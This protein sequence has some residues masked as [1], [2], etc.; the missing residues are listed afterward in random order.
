MVMPITTIYKPE[1]ARAI[2]E[3]D[4]NTQAFT[5]IKKLRQDA[6]MVGVREK[7]RLKKE[8]K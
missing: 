6:K 7:Q 4:K 2:S 3:E 5:T 1:S 8:D